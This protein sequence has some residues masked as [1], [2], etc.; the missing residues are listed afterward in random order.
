MTSPTCA[1]ASAPELAW[2]GA[3]PRLPC[4]VWRWPVPQLAIS[5]A[6]VGGGIT[7]V[8]WVINAQVPADYT[9]C[10]LDA[11]LQAIAA[12]CACPG[13]G[14]GLLT[15]AQ[16]R[17]WQRGEEAGV[18]ADATV[19]ISRP[20]YAADAEDAISVYQPQTINLVIQLPVRLTEAALVNAVI[21]ATEAKTQALFEAGVSGTG[22]ASDAVCIL[23]PAQGPQVSFAG[24]RSA[25]GA[26]LARA[27][28]AAVRAGVRTA[29]PPR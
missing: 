14:L 22:T 20:T 9:R 25:W 29:W 8:R 1:E 26:R 19:G 2:H 18:S 10:D 17:R 4:L 23:C 12:E 5:S 3:A 6:P 27:V 13:A 16:V 21:T 11:H 7:A 28:H 15:A 24:P